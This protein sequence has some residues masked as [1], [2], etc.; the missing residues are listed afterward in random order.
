MNFFEPG[1]MLRVSRKGREITRVTVIRVIEDVELFVEDN[2]NPDKIAHLYYDKDA[3][4][5]VP[6]SLEGKNGALEPNLHYML[7]VAG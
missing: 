5:W 4:C 6:T 1:T 7:G 2:F 3:N